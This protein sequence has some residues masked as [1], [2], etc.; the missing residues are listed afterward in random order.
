[1]YH[2]NCWL[3]RQEYDGENVN[4]AD[5]TETHVVFIIVTLWWVQKVEDILFQHSNTTTWFSK[6]VSISLMN[7]WS[8]DICLCCFSFVLLLNISE[9]INQHSEWNYTHL[10][11]DMSAFFAELDNNQAFIRSLILSNHDWIATIVGLWTM[12]TRVQQRSIKALW[13]ST[14][15]TE[16]TKKHCVFYYLWIVCYTPFLAITF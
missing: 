4:N 8:S 15:Y 14:D 16:F 9:N 10:F 2:G 3:Y 12:D 13:D 11:R 5:S 1:M 6:E 7:R